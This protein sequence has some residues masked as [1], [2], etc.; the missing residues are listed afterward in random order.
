MSF[1]R[2]T[3][4]PADVLASLRAN[5]VLASVSEEALLRIAEVVLQ[6]TRA[7]VG[8]ALK[9][10]ELFR[11]L[12]N[13]D[14]ERIQEIADPVVVDAD[15]LLFSEGDPGDRFYVVVRGAVELTRASDGGSE[16]L[17]VL[18]EGQAFGEVALLDDAPRP[19]TARVT[20]SSFLVGITREAF[21]DTVG[22]DTLASRLLRNLSKALRPTSEPPVHV[23]PRA[24]DSPR[25]ALVEY[26]RMVRSR[27]L[28]RGVPSLAG[29]DLAGSTLAQDQGEGTA[30]WDW[31]LLSDG[32]LALAVLKADQTSLSSAHR[33]MAV[34]GLLRDFAQD[35]L[36]GV[37]ALLTRVN[38]GLRSGWV[39]GISGTVSCG[40]VALSED[41]IE[42][43]SAGGAAGTVVRA[44][45][46]HQDLV[47][48]RPTLGAG[49]DLEYRSARVP[50]GP[51]DHLVIFSEGPS[52]SVILGRKFLTSSRKFATARERL[53]ALVDR[54]RES[55]NGN[56]RP[57]EITAALVTR[58]APQEEPP[59]SGADAIA[60]AAAAFDEVPEEEA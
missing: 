22:G 15:T 3:H 18:R 14:L 7:L 6:E 19:A 35:P 40:V 43:A 26:N 33:L 48:D 25:Q 5:P 4:V 36:P 39:D 11:G 56:A 49:E 29:Y 20:E 9:G 52:D 27:L 54:I 24:T 44:G 21:L 41:G 2:H 37:G 32:R 31:F 60:R 30:A 47:P 28:P 53:A 45:G 42:W 16:R 55:E 1:A 38:R 10:I 17:A 57:L 58:T 34:R 23:E 51:E 8:A 12:S 46:G 13:E 50:F 59:R